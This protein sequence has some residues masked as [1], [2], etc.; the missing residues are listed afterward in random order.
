M[1]KWWETTVAVTMKGLEEGED[2][3][4]SGRQNTVFEEREIR[5]L[6]SYR[7]RLF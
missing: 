6:L 4:K 2:V 5:S 3:G 7:G 1:A